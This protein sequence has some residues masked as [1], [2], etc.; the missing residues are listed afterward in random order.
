MSKNKDRDLKLGPKDG[1]ILFLDKGPN[2][3]AM[4]EFIIPEGDDKWSEA[5]RETMAFFMYATQRDD[6]IAEFDE[7][8]DYL[9]SALTDIENAVS[10]KPKKPNLKLMKEDEKE[11]PE[12]E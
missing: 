5:V 1:A 4:N 7:K 3:T 6:W 2:E 12:D 8:M 10:A 11:D 9:T